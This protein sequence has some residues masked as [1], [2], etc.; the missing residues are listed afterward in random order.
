MIRIGKKKK[1]AGKCLMLLLC[2]IFALPMGTAAKTIEEVK[3]Q[4]QELK[5]QNEEL[6]K[7]LDSLKQDEQKALE[8]QETLE[9]K[10]TVTEKRIDTARENIE[11]LDKNIEKL[12]ERL[13]QFDKEY[14]ETLELFAERIKA[15]YKM[16]DVGMLEILL[17][18]N[19]LY[20]F[21]MRTEMI[22]SVT[23]HDQELADK[24]RQ[25][26]EETAADR[27]DLTEQKEE[28]AELKVELEQ[29]QSDLLALYEENEALIASLETQ[30][31]SAEET[32]QNNEQED[33]EL[34]KELEELIRKKTEEE[35]NNQA[36][37]SVSP[38]NPGMSGD[39]H[40]MWPL[41][42]IGVGNITGN[43]GDMYFNGPHNGMDIGA[44]YGTP[45]V[46][47]QAGQVLSAEYHY[48]WGNNV[49]IWHNGTFST[50]YAHCSSLAVSAGQ[51]VEQG[52]VIGYVGSTGESFG[53]HL[54]FE[55][56][57][58]GSRTDPRPYLFG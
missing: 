11:A 6:Q 14:Q 36:G 43:Y 42:G 57:V 17:T 33:A 21:S 5:K 19:S 12:E 38:Q 56:Y 4:Q 23:K 39:F 32:I 9:E 10:I 45:I 53:N 34:N 7:K 35:K 27:E 50:R 58:N 20:D 24:I 1:L 46:A 8:Y 30:K 28:A 44:G 3:A 22:A 41:P 29:A 15:L 2:L 25:Y 48:S 54:H 49:L 47:A 55:V 16:G 52:Q 13:A 18:S 51:Y 40:P 31:S 26:M 37:G